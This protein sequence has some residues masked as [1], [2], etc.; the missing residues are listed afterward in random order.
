MSL[1][2]V[3]C[4]QLAADP[5]LIHSLCPEKSQRP[6]RRTKVT[7]KPRI[8]PLTQTEQWLILRQLVT[9]PTMRRAALPCSTIGCL[10][11]SKDFGIPLRLSTR[12]R[13]E[14]LSFSL[15]PLSPFC[16]CGHSTAGA[17]LCNRR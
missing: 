12:Q 4:P 14:S 3:V 15:P 11:L 8:I 1:H 13:A 6:I 16:L 5:Q 7:T 2:T 10:C 17:A 9:L